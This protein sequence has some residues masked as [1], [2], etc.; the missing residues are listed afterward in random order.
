MNTIKL[1]DFGLSKRIK[2]LLDFQ[3]NLF[4]M[5]AYIDP[6]IFNRKK[7]SNNQSQIYSLNKKVIFTVLAYSYGKYLAD[8]HLFVT[9]LMMLIWLWKYYKVLERNPFLTHLKIT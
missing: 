7:D 6:Q 5:V 8:G 3:T 9:N 4:E 1:T 2:K